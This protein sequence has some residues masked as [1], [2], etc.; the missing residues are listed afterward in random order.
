MMVERPEAMA[1]ATRAPIDLASCM[2]MWPTPPCTRI[3]SDAGSSF[4]VVRFIFRYHR[5]TALRID[6]RLGLGRQQLYET[7]VA[8]QAVTP[9]GPVSQSLGGSSA[10]RVIRKTTGTF[11]GT[12]G[13]ARRIASVPVCLS[14][15]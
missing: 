15:I 10:D 5:H 12:T 8:A 13:M 2:A 3:R 11:C 7:V 4:Q 14:E 9:G 1:V 6:K